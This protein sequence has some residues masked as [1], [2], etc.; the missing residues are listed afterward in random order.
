M[1]E[2]VK[3][4]KMT[5]ATWAKVN[6]G[7]TYLIQD[8][9]TFH[10]MEDDQNPVIQIPL[11][12]LTEEQGLELHGLIM[13]RLRSFIDNYQPPVAPLTFPDHAVYPLHDAYFKGADNQ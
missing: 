12:D 9:L 2:D 4:Y 8:G 6:L 5:D 7:L 3:R 13:K 11:C 1:T 10:G